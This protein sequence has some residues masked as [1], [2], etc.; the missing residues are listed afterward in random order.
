[1]LYSKFEELL[2]EWGITAYRV[3]KDTGLSPTLFSDWKSGK[4]KPKADK[5]L[6]IA[7]YFN[8]PVECLIEHDTPNCVR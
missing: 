4:S 8:V 3:S 1:M 5:L 6:I 7:N 2:E